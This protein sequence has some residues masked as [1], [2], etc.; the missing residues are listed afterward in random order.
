MNNRIRFSALI[1]LLLHVSTLHAQQTRSLSLQ[2]AINLSL[3]NSNQLKLSKAKIDF[4]TASL[5][6]A[7]ENRLPNVSVSGSYLRLN[8]PTIDLKTASSS[9]KN[10]SGDS[11]SSGGGMPSVNE[12]AYVMANVSIPVFSGF[13]IKNGIE[14]A[15][16]LEQAA[17]LDAE[18]DKDAVIQNTIAAYVNLYKAQKALDLVHE[19]LKQSQQRVKDFTNLEANG[20]IARNDLLKV[21]L[22][23]SNVEL[24]LL[25]AENNWKLT[26]ISMDLMLGFTDETILNPDSSSFAY[27]SDDKNFNDWE[28]IALENRKDI[29]A[30]DYRKNAALANIKAAKSG[31]YP[32][33]SVSGGYIAADIPNF[34]TITNAINV[35]VGLSY[36]PSSLWKTGSKVAQAKANYHQ[37]EVNQNILNDNIRL[38][39]AHVYQNFLSSKKKIEVYK[40]AYDQADENYRIVNN[41]YNNA[42]ATTTD[43]LEADVAQLQA[44]L[45]YAY[46]QADAMEAYNKLLQTVGTLNYSNN[47]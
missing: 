30:L 35:G 8:Q 23:E 26:N 39:T 32:S 40:N 13:R 5:K 19:N 28:T 37:L 14:A 1:I 10:S 38:Q 45:N 15:K 33:L 3:Q 46:A 43:L 29:E 6:E 7:R 41:K 42:L 4:A 9:S 24:T 16:Y 25:D 47:K 21:K 18:T 27:T 44:K 20:I 17:K 36:S 31:Y 34:L 22:Q 11:T 2:E 12:A